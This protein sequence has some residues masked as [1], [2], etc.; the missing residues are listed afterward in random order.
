[1]VFMKTLMGLIVFLLLS[2]ANAEAGIVDIIA[3]GGW[4]A[5]IGA[6]DLISGAGTNLGDKDS[7]PSATFL[8]V[9][10]TGFSWR[11]DVMRSDIAWNSNL[12]LYVRRTSDGTGSGIVFGGTSYASV[13]TVGASFFSGN[14]SRANMGVQYRL[15]S[16]VSVPPGTYSTTVVYTIVQQ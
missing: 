5:V 6:S 13:G 10:A 3:S 15:H 4:S 12:I 7:T 2:M 14:G 9:S 1:M 16:T 8:T 11:V